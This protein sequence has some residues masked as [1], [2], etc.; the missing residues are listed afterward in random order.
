MPTSGYCLQK[1]CAIAWEK[2]LQDSPPRH[3][4]SDSAPGLLLELDNVQNLL[5]IEIVQA[6][7]EL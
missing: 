2:L 1:D 7:T 4:R 5:G 3:L 6:E